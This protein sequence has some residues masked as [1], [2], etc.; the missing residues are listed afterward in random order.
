VPHTL[1]PNVETYLLNSIKE[2]SPTVPLNCN[3]VL[4]ILGE[5]YNYCA[6]NATCSSLTLHPFSLQFSGKEAFLYPP[7]SYAL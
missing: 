3:Y 1:W 2:A 6:F 5:S 7:S 4:G